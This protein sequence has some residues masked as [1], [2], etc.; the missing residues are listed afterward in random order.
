MCVCAGVSGMLGWVL[1]FPFLFR[2]DDQTE[3]EPEDT[4]N[5]ENNDAEPSGTIDRCKKRKFQEVFN[6]LPQTVQ[7]LQFKP[8]NN[9]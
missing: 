6:Q 5:A 2:Q 8:N 3:Q 7:D 1:K 4:A 9:T